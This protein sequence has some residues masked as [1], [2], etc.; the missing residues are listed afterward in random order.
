M[1]DNSVYGG[2]G[3]PLWRSVHWSL[4]L[5]TSPLTPWSWE[6]ELDRNTGPE[7]HA[8]EENNTEQL[9][10]RKHDTHIREEPDNDPFLFFRS[11]P[12]H[13]IMFSHRFVTVAKALLVLNTMCQQHND[14]G[15]RYEEWAVSAAWIHV[16]V[17]CACVIFLPRLLSEHLWVPRPA[18]EPH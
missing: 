4:P 3:L 9:N 1:T 16:S 2:D 15:W 5:C 6:T 12:P 13:K 7:S 17:E 18:L 14:F 8:P 10:I 11:V